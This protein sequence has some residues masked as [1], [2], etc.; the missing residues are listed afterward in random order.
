VAAESVKSAMW[1]RPDLNRTCVF[2]LKMF[3][4][5]PPTSYSKTSLC[6]S[7]YPSAKSLLAYELEIVHVNVDMMVAYSLG[8]PISRIVCT[9]RL[10]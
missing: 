9:T 6:L 8:H 10:K 1:F 3:P 4:S 2:G 5:P 7:I